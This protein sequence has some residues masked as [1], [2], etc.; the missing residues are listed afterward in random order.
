MTDGGSIG[1]KRKFLRTRDE[2]RHIGAL[3]PRAQCVDNLRLEN[4]PGGR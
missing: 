3:R 1:L 2:A 4:A